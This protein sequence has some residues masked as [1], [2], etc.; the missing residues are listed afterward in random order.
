MQHVVTR[1]HEPFRTRDGALEIHQ[2]PAWQDNLVWIAVCTATGEAAVVDGPDAEATLA[3]CETHGIRLTAILNTH[4]HMDHVGINHDLLRRGMLGG[5]RVH[6]PKLAASAVPG[7]TDPVDEGSAVAIGRAQGRVLRTEGH[8]DGHVSYVFDD[9]LFCGDTLFAGG[10]GY[11]F[12]GPPAK[13]HDSLTRLAALDP[14]TR[15]CC[16]HEYTQDNLRFA[17]SVEPDNAALHERIRRVWA[18]RAEGRSAVPSTIGEER[19]TNPFLRHASTTL[20]AKVAEA[21]PDRALSDA[22]SIFA[23]T[24]ALKD[25]KDYRAIPDAALPIG[26]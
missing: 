21:F 25:R 7:I 13:M 24:R 8:I 19:A 10:C 1:P 3:Y 20:R 18:L 22:E 4:T 5:V 12:D 9:V 26:P 11:L 15:V 6:G 17:F 23:A 14:A 2:V 16:A